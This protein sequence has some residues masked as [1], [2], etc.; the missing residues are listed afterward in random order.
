MCTDIP[1]D[2]WLGLHKSATLNKDCFEALFAEMEIIG[3]KAKLSAHQLIGKVL[4]G[5]FKF[6]RN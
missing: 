6:Y 2:L 1:G 5:D 4:I 3:E